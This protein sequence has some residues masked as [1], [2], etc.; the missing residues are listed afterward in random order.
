MSD[1]KNL[2]E[3][4][5]ECMYQSAPAHAKLEMLS[6]ILRLAKRSPNPKLQGVARDCEEEIAGFAKSICAKLHS[7]LEEL[8]PSNADPLGSSG[9]LETNS[10][11]ELMNMLVAWAS[12]LDKTGD[13]ELIKEAS[14]IDEILLTLAAPKDAKD[15]FK[16][17]EDQEIERL[18]EKYRSEALDDRY[19]RPRE[20]LQK[21]LK[22]ADAVKAIENSVK[23]YRPMEAPLSTRT[24]PDHPGAQMQRVG[25]NIY[26]C[27][28]DKKVYNY[29][30][31]FTTMKGN[32]VPGGDVSEQTQS[33]GDRAVEHMS[34]DTRE[35]KLNP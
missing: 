26:Q 11:I 3:L 13:P 30:G 5:R 22:T 33:L 4:V 15:A 25:D 12:E 2:K 29:R 34:F 20:E 18:R 17:A 31:G 19:K 23:E 32:Q 35:S 8:L 21:D 10:G 7:K 9:L 24:C 27:S 14:V 1:V 16:L 28:L 6:G